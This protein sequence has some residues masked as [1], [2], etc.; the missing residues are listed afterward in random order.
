MYSFEPLAENVHHLTD[1][2]TINHITNAEIVQAALGQSEKMVGFTV[3]H[4]NYQNH[5]TTAQDAIPK[6]YQTTLDAFIAGPGIKPP[7]LLKIDVEGAETEVLRG[8]VQTLKRWR[9]ILFLALHGA[10]QQSACGDLLKS[11]GYELYGIDGA[12]IPAAIETDEIMAIPC[13]M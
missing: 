11:L 13:E 10:E 6:V 7:Q 4:N 12:K 1:H 5:I 3:S 8:A 9:P 2:I